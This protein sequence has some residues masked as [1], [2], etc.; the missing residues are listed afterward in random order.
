MPKYAFECQNPDCGLS[1]ERLLKVAEHLTHVCPACQETAPRVFEGQGFAF[2]FQVPKE[3]EGNSGVHK[4]D[5]PTADHA[6]GRDATRRW[7]Y[8]R[9]RAKVKE[10]VRAGGG[11]PKLRRVDGQGFTEYEAL[12]APR[13]DARR[14]LAH[15]AVAAMAASRE[16]KAP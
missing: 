8:Y 6:V 13:A 12:T 1:F 10:D 11:T 9:T 14:S 2:A 15:K 3:K 5:Y 7:D 16:K 4:E